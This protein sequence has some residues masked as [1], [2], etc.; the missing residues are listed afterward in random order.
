MTCGAESILQLVRPKSP[1]RRALII[2][3]SATQLVGRQSLL[4][5]IKHAAAQLPIFDSHRLM[6]SDSMTADCF[7]MSMALNTTRIVLPQTFT[8]WRIAG[9]TIAL[10][11]EWRCRPFTMNPTR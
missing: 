4:V 5:V 11:S 7:S 9:N 10:L 8:D 3:N 1:M 6:L 2:Q